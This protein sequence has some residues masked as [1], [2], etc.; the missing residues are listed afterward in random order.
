VVGVPT[1]KYH[2]VQHEKAFR[3]LIEGLTQA[4][5]KDFKFV[6]WASHSRAELQIYVGKP[7]F[8]SV[9]LGFKCSNSFDRSTTI[10][11]GI[12]MSQV[13]SYIEI[14]GYR[15]VCSNGMI[16]RVPIANAEFVR[17]ELV[18]KLKKM[19][20][21]QKAKIRH[22][23][24]AEE[25]MLS[26]QYAVEAVA[27]LAQPVEAMIKASI[28]KK[29]TREEIEGIVAKHITKRYRQR[30]IDGVEG[31][32]LWDLYNS[33][34]YVA[35]HDASIMDARRTKILESAANLLMVEVTA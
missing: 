19:L 23:S 24:L 25:R 5:I 16:V 8:D 4:G 31:D 15:Q 33:I 30:I 26:I 3:P 22:N 29:L 28:D 7:G 10:Q 32:S 6:T 21:D 27:L 9:Q 34:T 14:V 35:S 2:L 18:V 12:K 20:F 17:P 11:Y 13:D 1:T